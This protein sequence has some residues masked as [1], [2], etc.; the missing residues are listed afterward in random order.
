M[1][2]STIIKTYYNAKIQTTRVVIDEI[3]TNSYPDKK[4]LVFGLGYD[5]NLWYNLT[6]KNTY[7]VEDN[8]AYIDLNK[9]IESS[10]ILHHVYKGITVPSSFKLSDSAIEAFPMPSELARLAPFDLIYIDGPTGWN[11]NCPGRLLPMYWSKNFLSKEGTLVYIDDCKRPLETYCI[12][13]FF[14]ENVKEFFDVG[15]G[16]MKIIL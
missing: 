3:A 2:V 16:C 8:Q 12:D 14:K 9:S 6:G 11:P 4:M 15:Q 1:D 7:F 5:S 13:K 10:H